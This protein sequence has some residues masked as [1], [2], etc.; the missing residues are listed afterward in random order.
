MTTEN[1]NKDGFLLRHAKLSIIVIYNLMT[2]LSILLFYPVLPILLG[3][4]PNFKE[5]TDA[6]GASYNLQYIVILL[7]AVV[8]GTIILS[9]AFRKISKWSTLSKENPNDLKLLSSIRKKCMNLP[10]TI[11]IAQITA[12]SLPLFAIVLAVT[13]VT[14]SPMI[15]SIRIFT[16]VLSLFT[17][18][19]VFSFA[20]S[21]RIFLQILYKTFYGEKPEGRRIS[22]SRQLFMLLIPL[23][24]VSVLFIVTLGYSRIMEEKGEVAYN[25]YKTYLSEKIVDIKDTSSS[26]TILNSIKGFGIKDMATNYF[27]VEPDGKIITEGVAITNDTFKYYIKHPYMGDR[28]YGNSNEM[29]GVVLKLKTPTGTY[30][31]GVMF[32]MTS[33]DSVNYFLVAFLALLLINVIILVYI[34]RTISKEL[35]LIAESLNEIVSGEEVNLDKKLAISSNDE[36]SDLLMAFNNIQEKE[37]ENIQRLHETQ[38]TLMEQERLASLGQLIAGI[39]HNM[40]TPIMSIS[41]AIEALKDLVKEYDESIEDANVTNLDHK[42]IASEMGVWLNKMRPYCGYMSDIINAVKEQT[43]NSLA[44]ERIE[45]SVEKLV[46]RVKMFTE[47]EVRK[48]NCILEVDC[49]KTKDIVLKGEISVLVQVINNLVIN[50]ADS[51][52]NK[53]GIV[54]LFVEKSGSNTLISIKDN[55]SGIKEEVKNRL[56]KEMVTSKGTEGIGLGLFISNSSIKARFNG[57]MWFESEEGKGS[58]FFIS[59]PDPK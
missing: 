30:K 25:I 49:E 15:L 52:D 19:G 37:K 56:F 14:N 8:I 55:G 13:F 31:V 21:R 18:A 2:A 23:I 16:I 1:K 20:F 12:M 29:Q 41:G 42:E 44:I 9:I 36:I 24:I 54:E 26:Q 59:I 33:S 57:K 38:A 4:A 5:A 27:V 7:L 34:S 50:A 48:R 10:Y 58:T 46:G 47:Q 17:L 6:I 39:S 53:E 32:E 22:L 28:T 11:L 40:R 43:V 45:F 35:A 3:Y 51:Y